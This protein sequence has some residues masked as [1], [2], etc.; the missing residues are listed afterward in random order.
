MHKYG[1]YTLARTHRPVASSPL[2]R[3]PQPAEPP[4]RP[5]GAGYD[6]VDC[7]CGLGGERTPPHGVIGGRLIYR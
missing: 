4:E 7:G 6:I 5:N 2:C 1:N 3:L